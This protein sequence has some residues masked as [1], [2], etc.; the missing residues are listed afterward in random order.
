M[1]VLDREDLERSIAAVSSP[2]T[3]Q[4][5]IAGMLASL[6]RQLHAA[7]AP[8]GTFEKTVHVLLTR[9]ASLAAKNQEIYAWIEA[10]GV[11]SPACAAN[12]LGELEAVAERAERSRWDLQVDRDLLKARVAELERA[13]RFAKDRM[14]SL[15]TTYHPGARDGIIDGSVAAIDEALARGVT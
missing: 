13:L 12:R 11:I 5:V 10:C 2:A 4:I 6:E 9:S 15:R 1:F 7:G 3:R 14:E 8:N